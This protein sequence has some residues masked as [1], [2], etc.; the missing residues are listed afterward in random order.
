MLRTFDGMSE[1]SICLKLI[2]LGP[3]VILGLLLLFRVSIN[4]K[5]ETGTPTELLRIWYW[6]VSPIG[7]IETLIE[8][9]IREQSYVE[10][11]QVS[12]WKPIITTENYAQKQ[13]TKLYIS[14]LLACSIL[15][16]RRM[17]L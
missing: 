2:I 5:S 1:H 15:G 17:C 11:S 4:F 12:H 7:R 14:T 16:F 10:N 9:F 13:I 8:L 6:T 3:L